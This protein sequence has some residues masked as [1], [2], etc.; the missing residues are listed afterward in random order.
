MLLKDSSKNNCKDVYEDISD[1]ND[2]NYELLLSN[3]VF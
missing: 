2:N 1:K 3:N